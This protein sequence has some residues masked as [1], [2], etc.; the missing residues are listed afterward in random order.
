MKLLSGFLFFLATVWTVS[1][2]SDNLTRAVTWDEY[3][4]M[5]NGE[6]VFIFA[7]EFH[8]ERLP[9]P[10]LWLDVLEKYKANGLNAV[11]IYFFWSYHSARRGVFDFTSPGKD[12]QQL[13]D[14][15]KEV[16][17]YVIARPGPYCNAET[18]GGGLALWGSDGSL[19][20]VRTSDDTYYQA[21]LPWIT[22]IGTILAK[23]QVTQGGNV[24]LDQIENE[25]QEN[26]HTATNTL[27]VYMEQLEN[28]TRN[29]GIVVPSSH[30]E[31]GMRSM[32]WS[33]D[34]ENVG[35]AV[36]VYGL[37]SYPGGLSCTNTESGFK[38]VRDYYQWF[39]NYSYTQPEYLPEFE[40]GY[41]LGWGTYFYDH[42]LEENDPAFADVYYKNNIGQRTTLMSLYMAFGG[43]NWGNIAAP[44]V[45]TSYDYSAP[46]RET[47][48]VR[49]KF[50]QTKL[51]GLFT[52]VSQDLLKTEMVGNGT[53]YSVSSAGVYSWVLRN[54]D[55][56]AGFYT[57][58][59]A[60][61]PSRA[62]VT[63]SVYL[64][65]SI[66]VI[67]VPS[68]SLDGRQSKILTTDYR[69]GNHTLLYSSSDVLTYGLF[70]NVAV[71]VLYVEVGQ[72]GEFAFKDAARNLSFKAYGSTNVSS[73]AG[74]PGTNTTATG[75]SASYT[76]YTYTQTAGSTVVRFSNGVLLYLLDTQTAW[77]FF[78]PPATSDPHVAPSEQVF[79][80]GPYN[81]RSVSLS[82]S[83]V[84]L[85][86]DNANTTGLEVY[87]GAS[88][89][90]IVWNG[91]ELA[92]RRT[93]YGSLIATAS[94]ANDRSTELP[95]L[96]WVVADALPE[97]RRD[98][99]DSRWV[100]CNKTTT[101][102][103]TAPLTLPVL[104]SSDYGYYAGIKIYRGY[105]DGTT[106]TSANITN[107]GGAAAGWSAWLNGK[108][109][110]GNTG[111]A[112][113]WATSGLLGF[114]GAALYNKRNVLT[115]VSD[116]TGHDETST[117]PGGV[118]NP[119]G[120]LGAVLYGGN[121]TL[122]FTQWKIQGNAGGNL[123][124]DPVRGPLN[125]DGL[126]GTRLGWHLPGFN[127]T[128]PAWTAGSPY[129]GRNASGIRWYISKFNLSID[130]DLDVPL[131]IELNAPSGTYASVQL[132]V[133]G[134]QYGKFIPQIGPQT[135]FPFPPGVINNRGE[136]T[137]SLALWAQTDAPTR[138]SNC[139]LFAYG[140]YQTGFDF[141][142]DWSDLQP[143]WTEDRLQYV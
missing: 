50:M 102:S 96:S 112:T 143:G 21:W 54:P 4:L 59:Q 123:N 49:P 75:H 47:R 71:L 78:A 44:V 6:R 11:S 139:T 90:R 36:N 110:G 128:G 94:G 70:G 113:L 137:I 37:D 51:I 140:A 64:N 8:Y 14:I 19:G 30:N 68:V 35:G 12:V 43:T 1:A 106:A 5:V 73:S 100:V 98:Y 134:Y 125:E 52:R 101:L 25:L 66:G 81:V 2:T 18:N 20:E 135:R 111:N 27:V 126:H 105:F 87:A 136:N 61:T 89:R 15:A 24:I 85:V 33:T 117:G 46:L 13:L 88:A 114:H 122:N 124:I 29:A 97:A 109:V 7:G 120:L 91:M 95:T 16:G 22:A 60:S 93:D 116:Y 26:S 56:R 86:G 132:Y 99:D 133:N 53:G 17:L 34:Y 58:Q 119:R 107:Q 108:F 121:S 38:V 72:T 131:G 57:L 31:K 39:Q 82:G 23:N 32:S 127:P 142:R 48:E 62:V 104:F 130:A 84:S 103:P 40:A 76:K 118:T 129:S 69:F 115:I 10:A 65:T 41:L 55:T 74:Y 63:F 3:S 9:N 42:C 77:T 92:T 141:S 138:L 83:T 45:Y 80:L 67:T 79:V 28:A